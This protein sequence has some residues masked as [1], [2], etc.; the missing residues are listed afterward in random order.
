[1]VLFAVSELI[2]LLLALSFSKHFTLFV[3]LC[4]AERMD[5]MKEESRKT[6]GL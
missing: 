2:Q 4:C 3:F 1:M 5:G 6:L